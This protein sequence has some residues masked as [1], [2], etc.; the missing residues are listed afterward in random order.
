MAPR[1][2]VTRLAF[3]MPAFCLRL[4]MTGGVSVTS[5]PEEPA[6]LGDFEELR[7]EAEELKW[8][9]DTGGQGS[10]TAYTGKGPAEAVHDQRIVNHN[11]PVDEWPE[12]KTQSGK[13]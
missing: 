13:W 8:L 5:R 2:T 11:F 7:R 3:R 4:C 6:G 9:F 1:S 12:A 10:S